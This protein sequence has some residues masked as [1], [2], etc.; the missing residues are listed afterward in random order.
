[1]CTYI[2]CISVS[3]FPIGFVS[4]ENLDLIHYTQIKTKRRH[5]IIPFGIAVSRK[6][7]EITSVGEDGKKLKPCALLLGM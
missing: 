4:M 2:V 3:M 6:P 5:H 1:M 7:Q